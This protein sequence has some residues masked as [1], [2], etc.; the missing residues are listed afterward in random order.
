MRNSTLKKH[1]KKK[2]DFILDNFTKRF[3]KE[4][5]AMII[6]LGENLRPEALFALPTDMP[7]S[8]E[9]DFLFHMNLQSD[10][11]FF[12]NVQSDLNESIKAILLSKETL[13][14]DQKKTIK[15]LFNEF[16]KS[17]D[18]SFM[19]SI[20]GI[21]EEDNAELFYQFFTCLAIN[22]KPVFNASVKYLCKEIQI[23]MFKIKMVY[24][25]H[26]NK[27]NVKK[28]D[29]DQFIKGW[30]EFCLNKPKPGEE[31]NQKSKKKLLV[32]FIN[33]TIKDNF[34][35]ISKFSRQVDDLYS[36][37]KELKGIQKMRDA[38]YNQKKNRV[39]V[40]RS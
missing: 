6:N 17:C 31:S 11:E 24:S 34:Y 20:L 21:A 36:Q 37:N 9:E 8:C 26:Q 33:S 3:S 14:E 23:N 18:A 30:F 7:I 32:S 5:E 25:F 4:K 16:S 2:N 22:N 12:M 29:I 38:I 13:S 1:P 10:H 19:S 39:D 40:K 35:D 28:E 15:N 27:D